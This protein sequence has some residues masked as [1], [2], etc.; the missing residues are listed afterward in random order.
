MTSIPVF[1]FTV[2]QSQEFALV[3]QACTV[4]NHINRS[5]SLAGTKLLFI[6]IRLLV[7]QMN[8]IDPNLMPDSRSLCIN[9]PFG[10]RKE[11]FRSAAIGTRKLDKR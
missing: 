3:S 8:E 6:N 9:C 4:S 1:E 10:F 7:Y 2:I 5:S 11:F